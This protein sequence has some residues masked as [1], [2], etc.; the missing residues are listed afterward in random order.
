[1]VLFGTKTGD[2]TLSAPTGF[3]KT[4]NPNNLEIDN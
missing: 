4:W 1:V 3:S 2:V